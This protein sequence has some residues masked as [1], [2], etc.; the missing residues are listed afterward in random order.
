MPGGLFLPAK[1]ILEMAWMIGRTEALTDPDAA[2]R[3]AVAKL[4]ELGEVDNAEALVF[5]I[6]VEALLLVESYRGA[7]HQVT[8]LPELSQT[9]DRLLRELTIVEKTKEWAGSD[10]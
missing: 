9:V 2:R 4:Q 7:R 5:P 8:F 1:E 6:L 3:K 10:A